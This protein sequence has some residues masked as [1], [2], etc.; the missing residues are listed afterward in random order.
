[1]GHA[2]VAA[3]CRF[4]PDACA[5][6][7]TAARLWGF[8]L[9]RCREE[10]VPRCG[11][12]PIEM[13][14]G[15]RRVRRRGD[16]VSWSQARIDPRSIHDGRTLRATDRVQTFFDLGTVLTVDDLIVIGD[17]LV[18][19]PRAWAEAGRTVPFADP[20]ALRDAAA[21]S[22]AHGIRNVIKA[23]RWVRQSSDSPMEPHIR[24]ACVRAGSPEPLANARL[25]VDGEELGMAHVVARIR[26]V[27]DEADRK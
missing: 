3:L 27:L 26:R 13:A 1:M 24:V 20:E 10:W 16:M 9:P 8:P 18:R 12:Q 23:L 5:R 17:H 15:G 25:I 11:T 14:S 4:H 21:R 2:I 6:R 19:R 22:C 7:L